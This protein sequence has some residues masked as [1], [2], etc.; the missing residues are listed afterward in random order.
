M[1]KPLDPLTVQRLAYV[2]F[3]YEQGLEHT[4][5]PAPLSSS[6]LLSFHVL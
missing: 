6:A 2:R 5:R 4:R 3:L 1:P